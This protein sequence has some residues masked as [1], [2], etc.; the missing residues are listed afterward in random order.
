M[1]Q[2]KT[3]KAWLIALVAVL[4]M[5]LCAA[6]VGVGALSFLTLGPATKSEPTSQVIFLPERDGV[7]STRVSRGTL[8][9]VGGPPI[10][11]D[12]ALVQDSTS[13]EYIDKLFV[14]LVS[15]DDE[16]QVRPELAES[17]ELSEN[18]T[19]YTFTLRKDARFQDGRPIRAED[20]RYSLERTCAPSTRSP[21]ASQ[22]LGDIVGAK[23][24]IAGLSEEV[25]GIEV[26]DEFTIQL[27]IDAPKA[28]FLS[29]LTYPTAAVVDQA[30]VDR[31]GAWTE[32][33]N[34]SGPY[35]LISWSDQLL[36]MQANEHYFRGKPLIN[37]LEFNL[38]AGDPVTMYENGELEVAWVG[39]GGF[40]RITDP[41][42]PLHGDLVA[43]PSLNVQYVGLNTLLPPFDDKN[44]RQAFAHATQRQAIVNVMFKG[45]VQEAR[46]IMPPGLP[47][48]TRDLAG[49]AYDPDL[50]RK[51][52]AQSRYGGAQGLPPIIL[53]T[54]AGGG[55]A[56]ALVD[57]WAEVLGVSVSV[58]QLEWGDYLNDINR[59]RHQMYILG[60]SADYPDPENFLDI[61]FRSGSEGNN[62]GYSNPDA[63]ALLD[64]AGVEQDPERRYALYR[65][66]EEIIIAEAP[67][68]PLFHGV[69]YVLIKP[70]VKE[71]IITSQGMYFLEHAYLE[72]P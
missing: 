67:W 19:V 43:V 20:I 5:C 12:P 68:I 7:E 57:M 25:A 15:L 18:G 28:Y 50:A 22:Y 14:G 13:A 26:L 66:V 53:A 8:R 52:L 2:R 16:L 35:R 49:L 37:R 46:G 64:L 72:G 61:L 51:L 58:V 29:K 23:E 24:R 48:Y 17:W 34:G 69:D 56:E 65:E 71:L 54:S 41:L 60:W 31:G 30:D 27:T 45:S 32:R 11:L 70:Y 10:T 39:V 55:M 9:L 38:R 63:D 40:E 59:G 21:V 42:N 47:G 36:V 1:E 6:C 3:G 33:P 44:V 4:S 62:S